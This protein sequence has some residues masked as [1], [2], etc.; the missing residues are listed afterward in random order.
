MKTKGNSAYP[1]A[2]LLF[3]SRIDHDEQALGAVFW[4]VLDLFREV[5]SR[6]Q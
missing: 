2:L 3:F 6:C 5:I 1:E 4:I